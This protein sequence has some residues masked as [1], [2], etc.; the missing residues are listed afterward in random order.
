MASSLMRPTIMC[1]RTQAAK[2][3]TRNAQAMARAEGV[4]S[5]A[6]MWHSAFGPGRFR[7]TPAGKGK[8]RTSVNRRLLIVIVIAAAAAAAYYVRQRTEDTRQLSAAAEA[9][10]NQ[11]AF[12][13]LVDPSQK[14][15]QE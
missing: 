10:E 1:G 6:S 13:A 11:F 8:G 4:R 12:G 3:K 14:E 2:A 15:L 7:A 9:V 5:R